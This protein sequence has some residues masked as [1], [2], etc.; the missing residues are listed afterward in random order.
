MDFPRNAIERPGYALEFSDEFEGSSLNRGKWLPQMLPHWSTLAA[1]AARYRV[2][3]DVLEL[4]V[5]ADQGPWR[6]GADIASNLST[7]QLDGQF[8]FDPALQLTERVPS[9]AGYLPRFGYFETRLRA[10]PVAGYHTALWLIGYDAAAAGEIRAFELHGSRM[11]ERTRFDY[12]ILRW[13]D[14][15]LSEELY[16]DWLPFDAREFHVYG[17]EWTASH[18]DFLVD[19][20]LVRRIGQS[21]QYRMQF[22]LGLY[23]RPNELVPGDPA[24][25]PRVAEVDYFR[26]YRRIGTE[27][28]R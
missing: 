24:P 11:G 10:C 14:P 22:M 20:T 17:L 15:A 27:T 12:G 21:P 25:Y 6:P 9:F 18:V 26:G 28:A 4:R 3:G 16:E 5:E 23:A 2:G 19:N 13:S 7:G 1:S 8:K